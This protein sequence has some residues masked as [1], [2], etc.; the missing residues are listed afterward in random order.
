MPLLADGAGFAAGGDVGFGAGFAAGCG[1]AGAAGA[2]IVAV[3]VLV[4]F[5]CAGGDAAV[6]APPLP[7]QAAMAR[8][9]SGITAA[10]A[11]K[12]I[13]LLRVMTAPFSWGALTVAAIRGYRIRHRVVRNR[14]S[15]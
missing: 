5:C 7:P 9:V 14:E 12:V 8:A 6:A 4:V 15:S 13:G 1:A 2:G 3:C 10:L 11:R